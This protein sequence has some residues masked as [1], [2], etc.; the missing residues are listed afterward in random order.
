MGT[1]AHVTV[2]ADAPDE[3]AATLADGACDR[4]AELERRWSRFLESSEISRLNAGGGRPTIVSADTYALV[5]RAVAGWRATRGAFDPTVLTALEA[6]GYRSTFSELAGLALVDAGP[7]SRAPGCA[8]IEL[9][10]ATHL[11]RLPPGVA[12]D[13]GGIGKGLAA[14]LVVDELLAAGATGACVN[15]GGDLR[16]AGPSP[17][18][19]PWVVD[20]DRHDTLGRQLR[21]SL[22]GG[23]VATTTRLRR[24]WMTADGPRH[25]LID[26][27][28]GRPA[29]DDLASV[30]VVA[31]EAWRAE[32]LAK[33]AF[34]AGPIQGGG[35][36]TDA[37]AAAL[38]VTA[39]AGLLTAGPIEDYL[40]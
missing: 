2:V 17:Q 18:G 29:P 37:G 24:R 23:A 25:H 12:I 31:G 19:R 30:V 27:A 39:D 5:T 28:T 33:A 1:V 15:V 6:N 4:L 8:G 35:L 36:V 9:H 14:D 13:P 21:L 26:P 22:A 20:V 32:V 3:R 38:F 7:A 11:V 10:D 40:T 16:A 34:V